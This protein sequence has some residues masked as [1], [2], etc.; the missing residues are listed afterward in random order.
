M[1]YAYRHLSPE[2]LPVMRQ[3]L[4]VFGVAFNDPDAYQGAVPSHDYLRR[5]LGKSHFIALAALDGDVV[6]GGLAAYE[7]EKFEQARSEIYIY[8]LAV[9]EP[10]RRRGIARGLISTLQGIAK[11]RGAWVIFVQADP[12]DDPAI[13]LYTSLGIREDVHH[14]DIPVR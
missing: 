1:P 8:D 3:L 10:H 2:D 13:R 6:V 5:L 14:F 7:L 4:T 11:Q 9:A 12:G